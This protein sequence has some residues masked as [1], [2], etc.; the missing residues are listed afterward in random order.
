MKKL[1]KIDMHV[2]VI[3][4]VDGALLRTTG[5]TFCTP[6]QLLEIYDTIGVARVQTRY[7]K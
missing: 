5:D 4:N 6:A 1:K 7:S 3:D 2:H